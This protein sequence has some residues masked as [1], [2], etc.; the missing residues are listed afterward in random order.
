VP[1]D[2]QDDAGGQYSAAGAALIG[3]GSFALATAFLLTVVLRVEL[4]FIDGRTMA[5]I[6][7]G[8]VALGAWMIRHSRRLDG[9]K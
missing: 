8:F 6:G 5:F 1:N 4:R 7:L 9:R 2:P 3:L